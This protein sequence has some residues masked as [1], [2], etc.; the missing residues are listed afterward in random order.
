MRSD[1]EGE[2]DVDSVGIVLDI[3]GFV[4]QPMCSKL[5]SDMKYQSGV[6]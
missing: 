2:E 4:M 1:L 3:M 6:Q 5:D